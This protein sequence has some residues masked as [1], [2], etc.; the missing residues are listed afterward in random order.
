MKAQ[1]WFA[2]FLLGSVLTSF[3]EPSAD[4]VEAGFA[5][6][7]ASARPHT[8]WH[9]M[10]GNI[11][12]EGITADLEAMKKIGLG[13]A[14][15]FNVDPDG[16]PA[17]PVSFMSDQWLDMVNHA[18]AEANRLG[19][20]ICIH[21]CAGW[22]SSGGPWNKPENAMQ[23]VVT[24]ERAVTG[25]RRFDEK[26]PLPKCKVDF[27]RDIAVLA[28]KTPKSELLGGANPV[29]IIAA[30]DPAFD[31]GRV[32]DGKPETA[33]ALSVPT[34]EKPSFITLSYAQPY[35]TRGL[36]ITGL[37]DCAGWLEC[38]KDGGKFTKIRKFAIPPKG[39]RVQTFYCNFAPVSSR[40]FRIV[41]TSVGKKAKDLPIAEISLSNELHVENLDGK[42]AYSRVDGMDPAPDIPFSAADVIAHGSVLDLTKY[43]GA[44]GALRWDVPDGE[45]TILRVGYTPTGATNHPAPKEGRG[46][47]CDKMSKV[48]AQAHW[49][50]IMQRILDHLG[51]LKGKAFNNVL[52]D[53]FE[54]GSQN[55]TPAFRE[56][57]LHRRGY[58]LLT[59]L[60]A[61]TGRIIDSPEVTDRFFWDIR[62][63]IADL[64]TENY[65]GYFAEMAHRNGLM[66]SV[67]PYGNGLF[68]DLA[69]GAP[70][71]INMGE[72]WVDYTDNPSI[73]LAASVAHTNGQSIVGAESFTASPENGKWQNHPYSLKAA[74]DKIYTRGINRFIFHRYAHQPWTNVVPGMTMGR[75]GF[76]FE[77]TLTWW[78]QGVAWIDYLTRC[79]YLLQQG[80]FVADVCYYTG[81]T[82]PSTLTSGMKGDLPDGFDYDGCSTDVLL[83]MSVKDGRVALP[84]G[85][86]Y[87][88]L[89]LP[90]D[91]EMTPPLVAKVGELVKAGATIIGQKPSRSPSLTNYPAC[92]A[93]VAKL[94]ELIWGNCD[95]KTVTEHVYGQGRVIWGKSVADVLRDKK[96]AA[97]FQTSDQPDQDGKLP[98]I[99]IHRR[100]DVTD[101]YFVSNQKTVPWKT[102]ATFRVSG[103]LPELWHPDTGKVE[104]APAYLTKDGLITVPL[105]FD[106]A[107][108]IFVIFRKMNPG[109]DPV[110]AF[111]WKGQDLLGGSS[112]TDNPAELFVTEQG[113][114]ALIA[115]QAGEY[116]AITASGR[117]AKAEIAKIPAPLEL[118][119]P[120]DIEFHSKTGAAPWKTTYKMLSSWPDDSDERIKYFAGTAVYDTS[121][122]MPDAS[123]ADGR[124][125]YL[126][127]GRVEV[128]AEVALNGKSL[129]I[130]WKP[131]FRVDVSGLLK[132]G[133]NRLEVKVT[134]LWPNR[135]IGDELLPENCTWKKTA[136]PIKDEYIIA[137]W[138]EWLAEG[139]PDPSGRQ[140]FTT[141]H[142]WFK[143]DALLP[144][145]LLG[146]VRIFSAQSKPL[147][148]KNP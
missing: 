84:D 134:N 108:S 109:A 12:K 132:P 130:L 52:I 124:R 14:Q 31:S 89:V 125:F 107:G 112:S 96:I 139:K 55:W 119:G 49:D 145:G 64:I 17:G 91:G 79:Q 115:S 82:A 37:A 136:R 29:P 50:G 61:F 69:C 102:N 120:W 147:I 9:W 121:F 47:E 122:V 73:K 72:F 94:A 97:D 1:A 148:S 39:A 51:P 16:M 74:G 28:F 30:S 78:D 3:A 76:H 98:V 44:D 113:K 11:S 105:H 23:M 10:N 114:P 35:E 90:Q 83:K 99:A 62:R 27:Y 48:A 46:L 7:P 42:A 21:N 88:L 15:I 57:F 36:A 135:L 85:M 71:D 93:E 24:T 141:F 4:K 77:R 117:T 144:S 138:P 19:L 34:A 95:G 66:L 131:P 143:G 110:V 40:Y 146:P 26:L 32:L 81:E 133:K 56:E 18:V 87:G 20:E 86:S 140:T 75:W 100:A 63:T 137:E 38:S 68:E 111:K 116:D 59:F 104:P 142:H 106:P 127:L 60:P 6:P 33:A 101:I 92:D 65:F 43:L 103:K 53:S 2:G 126:D 54:V 128:I 118:T 22:S 70:A 41:F 80:K 58:D 13:G 45:W 129:G 67:E 8:W 25:P 5:A 123:F